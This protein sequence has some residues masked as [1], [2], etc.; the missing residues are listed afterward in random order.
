MRENSSDRFSNSRAESRQAEPQEGG[1]VPRIIDLTLTLRPGMRGVAVTPRRQDLI[2][3]L[4]AAKNP[5]KS[6]EELQD[7]A[8][9]ITG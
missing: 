7:L 6:I 5:L 9:R 1:S 2:E 3:R 4:N 8:Y